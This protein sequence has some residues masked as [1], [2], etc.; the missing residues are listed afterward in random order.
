METIYTPLWVCVFPLLFALCRGSGSGSSMH[1]AAAAA[2]C[3]CNSQR[4]AV[5]DTGG[6]APTSVLKAPVT[7]RLLPM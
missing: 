4:T 7:A 2:A 5:G 1:A 6:T 3:D